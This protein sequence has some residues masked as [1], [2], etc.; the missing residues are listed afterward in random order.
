MSHPVTLKDLFEHIRHYE[1]KIYIRYEQWF[2]DAIVRY[3]LGPRV[4]VSE[5]ESLIYEM[6]SFDGKKYPGISYAVTALE[7]LIRKA[8]APE[9]KP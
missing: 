7:D 1:L 4:L 3:R 8:V 2:N 6:R 5:L 9:L